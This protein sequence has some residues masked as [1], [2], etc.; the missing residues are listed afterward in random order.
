MIDAAFV[1]APKQRNTRK[2]NALIKEG[3]IPIEWCKDENKNKLAQKDTDA[4]WTKK[5]N[6]PDWQERQ[7]WPPAQLRTEGRQSR[8]VQ[9]HIPCGTR[10]GH[11]RRWG[12]LDT[13]NWPAAGED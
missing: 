5:N 7:L 3:A 12:S 1:D 11:K 4:R 2:E 8:K 9:S 13:H 6:E 10:P